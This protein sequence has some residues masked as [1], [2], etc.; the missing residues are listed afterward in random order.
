MAQRLDISAVMV[1]VFKRI[2]AVSFII[3]ISYVFVVAA[4]ALFQLWGSPLSAFLYN[5]SF[6]WFLGLQVGCLA[7]F[8]IYRIFHF[9]I[10]RGNSIALNIFGLCCALWAAI[11]LSFNE[12]D[13]FGQSVLTGLEVMGICFPVIYL[14]L[15]FIYLAK[16]PLETAEITL[17]IKSEPPF[18]RR[19]YMI[20]AASVSL[21]LLLGCVI[22]QQISKTD[23]EF[24]RVYH[25]LAVHPKLV[26]IKSLINRNAMLSEI[27]GVSAEVAGEINSPLEIVYIVW[28]EKY[29][30]A[31]EIEDKN[32]MSEVLALR[33]HEFRGAMNV[34]PGWDVWN[35]FKAHKMPYLFKSYPEAKRDYVPLLGFMRFNTTEGELQIMVKTPNLPR[36]NGGVFFQRIMAGEK[37]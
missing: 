36:Q 5:L 16:P 32:R 22:G 1:A 17:K 25:A 11:A 2:A 19:R 18:F 13:G 27:G 30:K 3:C 20:A 4:V 10:M 14:F 6:P 9:S 34:Y 8:M 29:A 24:L 23:K 15:E 21:L 26:E 28:E 12:F 37:P 35:K 33:L 7:C 31:L